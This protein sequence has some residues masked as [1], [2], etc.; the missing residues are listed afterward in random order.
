MCTEVSYD[1]TF[2]RKRFF[3]MDLLSKD[4][5]KKVSLTF[6]DSSQD[7]SSGCTKR[8][9]WVSRCS[10]DCL[11]KQLRAFQGYTRSWMGGPAKVYF[12]CRTTFLQLSLP[13]E[14]VNYDTHHLKNC[15]KGVSTITFQP[16]WSAFVTLGLRQ[17][18]LSRKVCEK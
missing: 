9:I 17:K 1:V 7:L 3:H 16:P 8:L 11:K 10:L 15:L 4:V 14:I 18:P 12:G 13:C 2:D 6:F 5:K